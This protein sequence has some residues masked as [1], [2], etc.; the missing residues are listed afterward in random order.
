MNLVRD[1]TFKNYYCW[2]CPSCHKK[3]SIFN[4]SIFTRTKLSVCNALAII[5]EWAPSTTVTDAHNKLG[6]S[7]TTITNYY[8]TLR[9]ICNAEEMIGGPDDIVEI[10]ETMLSH[11][12]YNVGRF[13]EQ[14]WIVGGISRN[15]GDCFAEVVPDRKADTLIPLIRKRVKKQTTIFT[16]SWKAYDMLDENEYKHY[17]V[18]H[19]E[20]FLNPNDRNI[21]TQKIERMWRSLKQ[22]KVK[23][24][25]VSYEEIDGHIAEFIFRKYYKIT[26][27]NAFE[28]TLQLIKESSF[29]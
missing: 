24:Y 12:K 21:N 22:F 20:N 8:Q 19:S 14:V 25:G 16:E 11:A 29:C 9:D 26:A 15:T 1:E 4:N 5:N 28:Y 7:E 3:C 13:P 10:D 2:K 17:T 18:N 27:K 23:S 6:I